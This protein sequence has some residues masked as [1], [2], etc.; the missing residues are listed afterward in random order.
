MKKRNNKN[1]CDYEKGD[2]SKSYQK[3]V[4]QISFFKTIMES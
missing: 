3:M 2:R 1:T 4:L